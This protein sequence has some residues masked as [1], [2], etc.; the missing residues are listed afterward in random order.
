MCVCVYDT[1]MKAIDD[2]VAMSWE[3]GG[4]CFFII[5]MAKE[6]RERDP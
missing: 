3:D 5:T 6:E 2:E 4:I 1:H